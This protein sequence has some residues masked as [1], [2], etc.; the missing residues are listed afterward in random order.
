MG[1]VTAASNDVHK[2]HCVGERRTPPCG[3]LSYDAVPHIVRLSTSSSPPPPLTPWATQF[4]GVC[5]GGCDT[6]RCI[7]AGARPILRAVAATGDSRGQLTT[8]VVL[9]R[10]SH[11]QPFE[12]VDADLAVTL[13]GL[14]APAHSMLTLRYNA[15]DVLR[16]TAETGSSP[17]EEGQAAAAAAAAG[18]WA[19]G[20]AWGFGMASLFWIGVLAVIGVVVG[21]AMRRRHVR[22]PRPTP[23]PTF[24]S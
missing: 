17:G 11:A 22:S 6:G 4:D 2:R 13:Q 1:N 3:L 18:E 14:S 19:S 5:V 23:P 21:V 8:V 10:A 7:T 24:F 20:V 12:L 9:N 16:A 15:S